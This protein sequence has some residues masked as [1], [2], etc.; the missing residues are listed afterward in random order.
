M[1]LSTDLMT[2]FFNKTYFICD[3]KL[4]Q[5]IYEEKKR[6]KDVYCFG[7]MWMRLAVKAMFY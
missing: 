5:Y 4:L 7:R 1:A 2:F 3:Q 6:M